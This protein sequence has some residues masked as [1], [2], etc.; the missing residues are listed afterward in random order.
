IIEFGNDGSTVHELTLRALVIGVIL[1]ALLTAANTYLGLQLGMTVSA[2]IP[3]AVL[4]MIILR[5]MRLKDVSILEN[6]LVQTMA[7]AGES[8]AA[9]VIF[10]VPALL[11]MGMEMRLL[12]TFIIAVLGG[13]LGTMFTI[14]LRRVFIVE[15]QLPY[16]EGVACREVLVAGEK[17]GAGMTAIIYALGLGAMYGWVTK[18]FKIIGKHGEPHLSG[19][20][21]FLGTRLYI[22]FEMSLALVSVGYIVGIRIAS[23]IFLG[24]VIGFMVLVPILG[25]L[26]GWPVGMEPADAFMALWSEHIRFV[27]VGAMVV[28]GIYTLWSMRSTI[29]VGV[30]KA[31]KGARDDGRP[32][33]REEQDID[34]RTTF[35]VAGFIAVLTFLFY[36]YSI[37]NIVLAFVGAL[38]LVVAA[39]F[40][41][42]VA[43]YIAGVVGSSNSPVSGMT[44]ATLMATSLIVWIV[45]DLVMGMET[46]E[47]MYA[48]LLIASVVAVNAAIAGD[49][50]QDL[51][52]GYLVGAT[53]WKQQLGETLGVLVGAMVAPFTVILL[54]RAFRITKTACYADPPAING[55]IPT[56]PTLIAEACNGAL[57]AP[58]AELIGA[59]IQGV[60]GG[61]INLPMVT[62]GVIIAALLIWKKLPVMSVAIGIYLPLQL[63]SSI[64]IGGLIAALLLGTARVR[65]D[66]DLVE[67][68]SEDAEIM[69]KKTHD[70]GVLLSAGLIAGEALMGVVVALFIVFSDVVKGIRPPDEWLCSETAIDSEGASYCVERSLA[71]LPPSISALFFIWFVL[72]FVHLASQSLPRKENDVM[73]GN[74]PS[75]FNLPVLDIVYDSASVVKQGAID[76][77]ENIRVNP[78]EK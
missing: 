1:G 74:R 36:W 15:E 5:S 70:R 54:H 22:G 2:S 33:A 30:G 24:G 12:E 50:M 38:F 43:G 78:P 47:L 55:E 27:G 67:P 23:F 53:P 66:G 39:F 60:F 13:I 65:T 14:T 51:K 18:G 9:G 10:T 76:L 44:I 19:A 75:P 40:F 73:V 69:V 25:I 28:G 52:T 48:T 31:I 49:V 8:L 26:Q 62:L 7:S 59:I 64:M 58:Q 56:D 4:S 61:S 68:M 32:V 42:A 35:Y 37:G 45:G 46:Q 71:V 41:S 6:N 16:P 57:L 21:D 77:I 34:I 72:I 20:I 17:G 63:S 3:A 11:V 29:A